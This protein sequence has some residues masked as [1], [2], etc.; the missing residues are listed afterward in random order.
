MKRSKFILQLAISVIALFNPFIIRAEDSEVSE[1]K[2]INYARGLSEVFEKVADQIT[3]SMVS[4][5]SVKKMKYTPSSRGQKHQ[6]QDPF[7]EPFRDFF[8]DDF[9]DQAPNGPGG[10]GPT[11]QGMGTGVI[12]DDKGHILTNN[13]VV[14][15]ADE[16]TVKLFDKRSF[17]AQIVGKDPR[18]DLAV[19]KIKA[20]KI[21]PAKLGD[22]DGL[23]IGEWVVAAGNPFGLDNSITAGIVSAKGRSLMGGAQYE[24][25]IQTDAAINPGN[26]GGPLVNLDGEVVGINTAIF[27]RSGGYMGIG[28]AIPIN[29]ASAIL[30]SLINDGKVVRGWLGIAIQNL[31]EDLA[32]SFDYTS[33]EGALI[34]HVEKDGPAEKAGLKQGDIVV[35]INGTPIKDVTQLRNVVAA[36]V[37]GHTASID[38]I[39]EGR[40]KSVDVEVGELPSSTPDE[41]MKEPEESESDSDLGIGIE[42]LTAETA[43]KLGT[44]RKEGVVVNYVRPDGAASQAGI[45]P[46]D[47]IVKVGSTDVSDVKAFKKAVKDADLNKGVRLVI[48][49]QGMQRYVFLKN[50]E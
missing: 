7:F 36:I 47:I 19:I 6:M 46:R 28:F 13:H 50:T 1:K 42:N 25:F 37:P 30:K 20:D 22:S 33:A 12:I 4:I 35:K 38:Y 14:G 17:K 15:D 27:S 8:G 34:G 24:D 2:A 5:S 40:K 39:R 21:V 49:N 31:T 44:D 48:E 23:K 41:K 43:H 45:M 16:V 29:M 10:Q 11:Q 9:F 18:T 32:Q 3:P 26:S